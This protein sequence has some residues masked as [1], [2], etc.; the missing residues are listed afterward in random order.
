[1]IVF[2]CRAVLRAFL[3]TSSVCVCSSL[4]CI[5]PFL[6]FP[7]GGPTITL[8]HLVSIRFAHVCTITGSPP[9]IVW[10]GHFPLLSLVIYFVFEIAL[11]LP[12][13]TIILFCHSP[14]LSCPLLSCESQPMY[15]Y[16]SLNDVYLPVKPRARLAVFE[17]LNR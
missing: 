9:S 12:P 1:M 16:T 15:F 8:D 7:P 10:T 6:S 13:G 4:C 17:L 5:T 11:L 3:Y 2:H 14:L